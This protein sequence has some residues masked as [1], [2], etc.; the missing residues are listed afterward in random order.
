MGKEIVKQQKLTEW[1][2]GFFNTRSKGLLSSFPD[3]SGFSVD[4]NRFMNRMYLFYNQDSIVTAQV[5]QQLEKDAN[6]D[7]NP[8]N[9]QLVQQLTS[10]ELFDLIVSFPGAL[11][12][13]FKK[14]NS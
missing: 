5:V 6:N 1:D 13:N 11:Y 12:C 10:T 7:E 2:D 4:N 8:N 3:I 14:T 9:P